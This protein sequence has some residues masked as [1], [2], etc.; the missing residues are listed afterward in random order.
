MSEGIEMNK[1]HVCRV[2]RNMDIVGGVDRN[3]KAYFPAR[4]SITPGP[5]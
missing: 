2:E 1:E 4:K 5:V 3:K